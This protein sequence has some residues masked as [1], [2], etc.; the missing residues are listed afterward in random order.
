M[1]PIIT[2]SQPVSRT[3]RTAS[4][5]VTISPLPITGM[6]RTAAFTS[7]MRVQSA[8][9]AVALF[10]RARMQRDRLQSA[11]FGQLRHFHR[12]Q[13]LVIPAGAKLHGERDRDGRAHLAQNLLHQ[14]QIAQQS[15]AAVAFHDLIH[16]AA[17]ID[18]DNIEPEIL[19]SLGGVGHHLRVGA[20]Q[21]RGNR[22][23]FR[24][25]ITDSERSAWISRP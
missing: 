24:L 18:V 22:M 25:E 19:A 1:R 4:S 11:I 20:E 9:P 12:D 17:E 23:L 6:W 8:L 5:G 7:A 10:A 2:A 15:R 14:R 3:M 16:R 13:F 21:L